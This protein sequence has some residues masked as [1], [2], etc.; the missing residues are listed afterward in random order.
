V[1]RHELVSG[2]D[3]VVWQLELFKGWGP[4]RI[5]SQNAQSM[6]LEAHFSYAGAV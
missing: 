3:E 1:A 4:H 6:V 5:W 2:E